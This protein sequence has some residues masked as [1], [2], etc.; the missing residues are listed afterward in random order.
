MKKLKFILTGLCLLITLPLLADNYSLNFDGVDDYVNLGDIMNDL[1]Q[2]VTFQISTKFNGTGG[3]IFSTDNCGIYNCNYNGYWV[4][5]S[6]TQISIAYGDGEWHGGGERRSGY[7]NAN[8]LAG[9]W[10]SITT[11]VRGPQDMSIYLND[12]PLNVS[13]D[14]TGGSVNLQQTHSE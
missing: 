10:Y 3:P 2:P 14:G 6:T 5:V 12:A 13:Y 11:I 1:Y 9:E 4:D 8:L 7:A